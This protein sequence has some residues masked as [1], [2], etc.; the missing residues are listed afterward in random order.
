MDRAWI[1]YQLRRFDWLSLLAVSALLV[2][3]VLFIYSATYRGEGMPFEPFYRKQIVWGVL[4]IGALLAIALFDYRKIGPLAWVVYAASLLLLILVLFI[5]ETRSGGTRWLNLF[6]IAVQ[7]SEFAK[8]GTLLLL[9]WLLNRPE[10]DVREIP[11]L[12]IVA[13]IPVIPFVLIFFQPDLGTAAVLVPIALTM[14]FVA[15]IALRTLF[16]LFLCGLLLLPVAWMALADYQ[17]SRIM[18]FF[19]PSEQLLDDVW[20]KVQSEIAVGS[21]GLTGKGYLAGTQ[22]VLGF[23]PH[24]IAPTDF[25]YSVVAEET[26]FVGC[27]LVLALYAALLIGIVRTAL[28]SPDQFGR[29]LAMGVAAMLFTH[30]FVNIAM[31]IGLMPITGL[32]LPLLSYGGSFTITTLC[33]LGL[34]QSVH[35]RRARR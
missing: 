1:L 20:N 25:V 10:V 19:N 31:T 11:G 23:L 16:K 33:A 35:I 27:T 15:G 13:L 32:P 4:G 9:A 18:V 24:K 34:V 8:I 12:A 30:V 3:G 14:V 21:G 2:I 6:G 5:G 17:R 7:P 28:L 29:F 26:G 22:H